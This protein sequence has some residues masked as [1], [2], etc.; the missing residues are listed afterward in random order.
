MLILYVIVLA[1]LYQMEKASK[2][3]ME[4]G[5]RHEVDR[6]MDSDEYRG[7]ASILETISTFVLLAGDKDINQSMKIIGKQVDK[8]RTSSR[9]DNIPMRYN[10]LEPTILRTSIGARGKL[11]WPEDVLPLLVFFRKQTQKRRI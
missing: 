8:G 6:W 11:F 5:E 1:N 4:L 10:W 7:M 9:W 3:I 2:I